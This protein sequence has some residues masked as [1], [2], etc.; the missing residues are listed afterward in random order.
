MRTRI[1]STAA[2]LLLAVGLA[3]CGVTEEPGAGSSPSAPASEVPA[4]DPDASPTPDSTAE[5]VVLPTDCRAILSEDVLDQLADVPLNDA[6][7]GPSG[8]QDDGSLLCIWGDPAADTTGLTTTISAMRR[9][10]ALDMLNALAAD[11]GFTC[12]TPD[13]GTR[14]EKTWQN[15]QY[16]VTDGRTLYWRDGILIDTRYSNL[17]P[18]GYTASIVASLLG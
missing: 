16:P 4:V 12:Y 9:G 5:A 3:G 10:P 8:V 2:V 18:S 14:C 6:A 17:A 11:E 13:A 7:F 15:E 1:V